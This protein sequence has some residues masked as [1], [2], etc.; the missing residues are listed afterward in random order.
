MPGTFRMDVKM[1]DLATPNAE[2]QVDPYLFRR[3]F[4]NGEAKK[5][6]LPKGMPRLDEFDF[7]YRADRAKGAG[8]LAG[9]T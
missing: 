8:Q 5:L 3:H 6:A 2:L 4:T 7:G 1:D 9:T